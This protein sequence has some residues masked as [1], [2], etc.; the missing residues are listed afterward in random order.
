M[1]GVVSKQR[2]PNTSQQTQATYISTTDIS[3]NL[4]FAALIK[5]K[6]RTFSTSDAMLGTRLCTNHAIYREHRASRPVV[7]KIFVSYDGMFYVPK[8]G[9]SLL[10]T[11]VGNSYIFKWG[12]CDSPEAQ[13]VERQTLDAE[14]LG[15]K[16]VVGLNFI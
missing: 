16:L 13:L 1:F 9:V 7:F 3:A 8:P 15:S 6:P 5:K 14:V 2:Q 4:F 12:R 11:S 10:N